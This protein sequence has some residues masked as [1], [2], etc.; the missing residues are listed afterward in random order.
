MPVRVVVGETPAQVAVQRGKIE[1]G[2]QRVVRALHRLCERG[3]PIVPGAELLS[4]GAEPIALVVDK[5]VA[6]R[7]LRGADTEDEV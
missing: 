2:L 6:G 3:G 5:G 1:Q 4:V 7:A